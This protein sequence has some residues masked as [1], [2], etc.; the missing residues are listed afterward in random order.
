MNPISC[1]YSET[2]NLLAGI[3]VD[4]VVGVW[5]WGIFKRGGV[6]CSRMVTKNYHWSER[7]ACAAQ[8]LVST[9]NKSPPPPP[10]ILGTPVPPHTIPLF[11][12]TKGGIFKSYP[13]VPNFA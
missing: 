10:T 13:R 9:I 4:V 2:F 8:N 11:G 1:I 12:W 6:G 5:G 3:V 7:L